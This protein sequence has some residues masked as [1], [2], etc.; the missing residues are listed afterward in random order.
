MTQAEV[1]ALKQLCTS[2]SSRE[3]VIRDQIPIPA[4]ESELVTLCTAALK[5]FVFRHVG[6][7]CHACCL[8]QPLMVVAVTWLVTGTPRLHCSSFLVISYGVYRCVTI[9]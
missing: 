1:T 7:R 2:L 3:D 6:C 5:G 9:T 8:P 4:W